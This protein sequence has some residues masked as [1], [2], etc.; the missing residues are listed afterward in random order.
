VAAAACGAATGCTLCSDSIDASLCSA[1]RSR[2]RLLLQRVEAAVSGLNKFSCD[3]QSLACKTSSSGCCAGLQILIVRPAIN[4]RGLAIA[5][6]RQRQ[7][8]SGLLVM[9]GFCEQ[10]LTMPAM[11]YLAGMD[12]AHSR[13]A[14]NWPVSP[15]G[16]ATLIL[17]SNPIA[18]ARA[19]HRLLLTINGRELTVERALV[20]CA[21]RARG[22]AH[23]QLA[24]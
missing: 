11:H 19:A 17:L 8:V 9:T 7:S 4:M 20:A 2:C 16:A 24:V 12:S 6:C 1:Q 15:G 23:W 18:F 5:W 10:A 22:A 3:P 14:C 21:D 13:K